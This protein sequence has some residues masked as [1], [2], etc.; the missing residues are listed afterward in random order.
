[1]LIGETK[2]AII[3]ANVMI[4]FL[5]SVCRHFR[6]AILGFPRVWG[7]M[8]LGWL[9]KEGVKRH[10]ARSKKMP[11]Y[12]QFDY[13]SDIEPALLQAL[14]HRDRWAYLRCYFVSREGKVLDSLPTL[15]FPALKKLRIYVGNDV[16]GSRCDDLFSTWSFPN[17]HDLV[18]QDHIPKSGTFLQSTGSM[19]TLRYC[20]EL[21]KYRFDGTFMTSLVGLL[22]PASSLRTLELDVSQLS[23]GLAAEEP[24]DVLLLPSVT[25]FTL[26]T[27]N[28]KLSCQDDPLSSE[29]FAS[30]LSVL[31]MPNIQRLSIS[32]LTSYEPHLDVFSWPFVSLNPLEK[33]MK[34]LTDFELILRWWGIPRPWEG[35]PDIP[36][37]RFFWTFPALRNLSIDAE[38]CTHSFEVDDEYEPNLGPMRSLRIMDWNCE[39][40]V[41]DVLRD[42]ERR[43]AQP[44]DIYIHAI[45]QAIDMAKVTTVF[46]GVNITMVGPRAQKERTAIPGDAI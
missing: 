7:Y 8:N 30:I 18:L 42:M 26:T 46:P 23:E 13:T 39:T 40:K 14:E 34:H 33:G 36:I 17:L 35:R 37:Y 15:T 31:R 3:E 11:L 10:L 41:H 12:I 22:G 27:L 44:E 28:R 16:G 1:M 21:A 25:H 6:Q 29:D 43:G 4:S 5:S 45:R 32:M 24:D 20:S 19:T 2:Y 9:G 38:D